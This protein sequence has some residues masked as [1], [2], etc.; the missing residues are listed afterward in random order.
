MRFDDA[1]DDGQAQPSTLG[2]GRT[3]D[4]LEGALLDFFADTATGILEFH[5]DLVCLRDRAWR[6]DRVGTDGEGSTRGHGFGR[7][8]D[9]IE[10]GL[11]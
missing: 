2:L 7:I 5:G 1:S 4:G 10:K 11:L 6:A 3:Q 8:E 9:E